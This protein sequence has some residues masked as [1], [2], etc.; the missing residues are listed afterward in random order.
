MLRF[1]PVFRLVQSVDLRL[2]PRDHKLLH[3]PFDEGY[4]AP[5]TWLQ[6]ILV[7]PCVPRLESFQSIINSDPEIYHM[8]KLVLLRPISVVAEDDSEVQSDL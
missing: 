2:V 4:A 8:C 3:I 1:E 7:D 6:R 5:D